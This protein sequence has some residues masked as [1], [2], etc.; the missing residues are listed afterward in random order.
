MRIWSSTEGIDLVAPK[1]DDVYLKLLVKGFS[2]GSLFPGRPTLQLP[3]E[4]DREQVQCGHPEE[5]VHEPIS[6][7]GLAKLMS[8]KAIDEKQS[9]AVSDA[10]KELDNRKGYLEENKK[11]TNDLLV[12]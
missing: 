7:S 12:D 4:D 1:S 10:F 2:T 8:G 3:R 9:D 11:L 6:I 5:A